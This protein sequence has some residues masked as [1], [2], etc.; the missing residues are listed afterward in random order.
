MDTY[1]ARRKA[2]KDIIDQQFGGSIAK[3]A[4]AVD[5][6]APQ[7]SRWL[8]VTTKDPRKITEDSARALEKK[9][10]L[11]DNYLDRV[12]QATIDENGRYSTMEVKHAN[13]AAEPTSRSGEAY[14]YVNIPLINA[15][16]SMGAGELMP[17]NE[18][19]TDSLRL[20]LDWIKGQ[21]NGIK[22]I[23]SLA[24]IHAIGDSMTPTFNDGDILLVDTGNIEVTADKIYV[25]EAHNRLFIKRVRQRLDGKYEISSDNPAIKTVDILNGDHEVTIKGRVV[26]AWNGKRL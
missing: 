2:L 9:L 18:V 12:D 21:F 4:E 25:L 22:S 11:T 15:A 17:E 10:G 19:I 5:I 24:F 20:S 26:W 13:H 6:K 23:G 8:S 16:G 14:G 7:I 3:L 1:E